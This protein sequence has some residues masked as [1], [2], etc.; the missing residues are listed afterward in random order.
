MNWTSRPF[1]RTR[2]NVGPNSNLRSGVAMG[3]SCLSRQ[4]S[5][6]ITN[7]PFSASSKAL[8]QRA[9]VIAGNYAE[10]RGASPDFLINMAL[11]QVAVMKFGHSG[12]AVAEIA[13]QNL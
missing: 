6:K 11:A 2:A 8:S 9:D 5:F 4:L 12:R 13:R 1:P 10:F 3:H 7:N